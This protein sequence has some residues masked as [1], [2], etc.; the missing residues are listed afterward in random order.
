MAFVL[1]LGEA[2][3]FQTSKQV[4]AYLGLVPLENSSG[5]AK[6]RLGHITK[7]GWE[8]YRAGHDRVLD[9]IQHQ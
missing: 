9:W 5:K 2:E 4:A 7:Q 6:Q 3:R 1:T 8:D